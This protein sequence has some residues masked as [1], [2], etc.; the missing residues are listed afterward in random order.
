MEFLEVDV[1]MDT[2]PFFWLRLC[3]SKLGSH[4]RYQVQGGILSAIGQNGNIGSGPILR[5][6]ILADGDERYKMSRTSVNS[7]FRRREDQSLNCWILVNVE[8]TS[9]CR[10]SE[11]QRPR[12]EYLMMGIFLL[13]PVF[14][15]DEKG[16]RGHCLT[17]SLCCGEMGSGW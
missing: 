9:L 15:L 2:V 8:H 12:D 11:R 14:T 6:G 7:I 13:S 1:L 17:S 10:P 3:S 16:K 5:G 4:L